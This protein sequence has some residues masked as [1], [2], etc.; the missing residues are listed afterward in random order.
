MEK[1]S[2]NKDVR[3]RFLGLS[4]HQAEICISTVNSISQH[5]FL[6]NY[7]IASAIGSEC[8]MLYYS[9]TMKECPVISLLISSIYIVFLKPC[10]QTVP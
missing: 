4:V 5:L 10:L 9:T 2:F 7:K 6:L 3:I 8:I 1:K